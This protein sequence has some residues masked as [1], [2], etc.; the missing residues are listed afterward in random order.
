MPF[1]RV[2]GFKI[3]K[4]R[5][6]KRRC[7]HRQTGAAVDLQRF[8]FGSL[9]FLTGQV[10]CKAWMVLLTLPFVRWLR[11]RDRRLGIAVP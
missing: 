4:D 7:Y 8:P 10:I 9:E 2:K 11:D 3:F 1:V 5:H 6:G